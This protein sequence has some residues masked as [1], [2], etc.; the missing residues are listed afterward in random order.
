MDGWMDGW[1]G[2][3][4]DRQTQV[5]FICAEIKSLVSVIQLKH[6]GV[7]MSVQSDSLWS[8]C[9]SFHCTSFF[10][11]LSTCIPHFPYMILWLI[12]SKCRIC[13]LCLVKK[14]IWAIC[15]F[16]VESDYHGLGLYMLQF[17]RSNHKL[18]YTNFIWI[19][20]NGNS[21]TVWFISLNDNSCN[22]QSMSCKH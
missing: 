16:V 6:E 12:G 8:I 18:I 5:S 19:T 3:Q 13:L 2:R 17:K 22:E 11:Q 1:M 7:K 20:H 4:M 10:I 15:L 14:T 21:Y 9:S